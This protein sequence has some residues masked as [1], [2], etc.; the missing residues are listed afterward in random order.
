LTFDFE[1]PL[2]VAGMLLG[3]SSSLHCFGMCSGIAASLALL[4]NNGSERR[5]RSIAVNTVLVHS[6]RICAYI[7]AGAIVGTMGAGVFGL[8]D[9]SLMHALLRWAAG[10]S[11][12]WVGLSMMNVLPFPSVFFRLSSMIGRATNNVTS[13]ALVPIPIGTFLSGALWGFLPCAMSYAALFYAMLSASAFGGMLVMTGFGLGTI[14]SLCAATLGVPL[15]RNMATSYW[16]R[17]AFGATIIA[18]GIFSV[19]IP[20]DKFAAWC[21]L[22]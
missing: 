1:Q 13:S 16:L 12:G 22:G 19:L 20:G 7:S 9:R 18:L 10:A 2:I 8:F 3:L 14:P 4:T 21:H 17:N 15:L 11:L 6:G 5:I